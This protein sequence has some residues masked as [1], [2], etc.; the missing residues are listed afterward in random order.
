MDEILR[1]L[2]LDDKEIK[3]YKDL[4]AKK[5][6][7]AYEVAKN[8][9]INRSTV[10]DTL[11]RLV[12]K[13]FVSSIVINGKKFYQVKD[14]GKII[15]SLKEKETLVQALLPEI[16]KAQTEGEVSVELLEGTE[17]QRDFFFSLFSLGKNRQL[18][19]LH[20]IGSGDPS[21]VGSRLYVRKLISEW[22]KLNTAKHGEY[23]CIWDESSRGKAVVKELN[24]GWNSK[25]RFLP[26]LPSKVTT[27]VYGDYVAFSFT[28]DKPYVIRIKNSLVA[29]TL[30]S[31]FGLL[32]KLAK[33]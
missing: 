28:I 4:V 12:R 23:K 10:Y 15:S 16:M 33:P 14:I 7:T 13:G 21:T 1:E 20:M 6:L 19:S 27:L 26:D 9:S 22:K 25:D 29:R 24:F 11:D 32:W 18:K 17:G 3:I 2:R 5:Q 30:D 31:Y 8:T